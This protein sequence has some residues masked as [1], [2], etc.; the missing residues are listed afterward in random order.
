MSKKKKHQFNT[1]EIEQ[2]IQETLASAP[3]EHKVDFDAW[4][5]LRRDKIPAH[6]HKEIIKADFAGRKVPN[7]ATI[8]EF[9]MALEKYGIKLT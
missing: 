8:A 4:Y 7:F 2:D 3:E 1:N 5:A 6:H 9:D